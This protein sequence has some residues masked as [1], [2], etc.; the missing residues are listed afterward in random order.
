VTEKRK[1]AAFYLMIYL[2]IFF[3]I[4]S[5][6]EMAFR[7][8]WLNQFDGF[9]FEI[10]QTLTKLVVW[11]L[12]AILLIKHFQN[13]MW[14]SL[15]DMFTNKPRWFKS[16]PVLLL[17]FF[18]LISAW[19]LHGEIAIRPSFVPITLVGAVVSSIFTEE[20]VFRGFLLNAMLKRMKPWI[21]I[22]INS[23]LFT[24]IH[25]PIW[26]YLG[27]DLVTVLSNSVQLIPIGAFFA[28]SFYKTKNIFVPGLLHLIWNLLGML[29]V[30]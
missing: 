7:P 14:V 10:L 15:K 8:I 16:A 12:P 11:A 30:G 3:A 9:T 21:A 22:S 25:Y 6:R 19:V 20:I 29:F 2:I 17:V 13:D 18:P 1:L 27:L 24:L 5:V 28:F 4:W 26:V 23:I